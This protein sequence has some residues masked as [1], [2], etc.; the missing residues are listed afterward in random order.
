[1]KREGYRNHIDIERTY[2]SGRSGILGQ[3]EGVFGGH[4]RLQNDIHQ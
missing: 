4:S 3:M 2:R 1:M